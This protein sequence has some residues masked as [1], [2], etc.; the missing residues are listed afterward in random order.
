VIIISGFHCTCKVLV[1]IPEGN[2]P[3]GRPRIRWEENISMDIEESG[4]K[5]VDWDDLIQDRNMWP[6]VINTVINILV[7]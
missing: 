4:W 7:Q 5:G 2:K 3:L 6:G 1:G